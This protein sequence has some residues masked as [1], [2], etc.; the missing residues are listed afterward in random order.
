M[1]SAGDRRRGHPR[2]TTNGAL[3]PELL[4]NEKAMAKML[5]N[6]PMKRLGKPEEV[7]ETIAF[8][9]SDRCAFITGHV[10]PIAGGWA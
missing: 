2:T 6:I 4:A 5:S 10:V 1:G 7:A 9:V 8:L 3:G